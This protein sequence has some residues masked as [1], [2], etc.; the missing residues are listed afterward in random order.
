MN[1]VEYLDY[2]KEIY[3]HIGNIFSEQFANACKR[4]YFVVGEFLENVEGPYGQEDGLCFFIDATC[5]Q[6]SFNN[7][8][9]YNPKLIDSL[10][11]AIPI[12]KDIH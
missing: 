11:N 1:I 5:P 8:L 7:F 9:I 3:S 4:N 2:K 6:G 10:V 12:N